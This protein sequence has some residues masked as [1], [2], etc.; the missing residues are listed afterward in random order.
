MSSLPQPILSDSPGGERAGD[1]TGSHRQPPE[2]RLIYD[3]APIGLA[4]L[5]LDCRYLQINQRLTEICGISVADHIGRSVRETVPQVADQVEKIVQL[6]LETG[7]P[8]TGIEVN[9]QRPDGTNA[10]RYWLTSWHPLRGAE[11]AIVGVNVVAEEITER[12]R[13]EAALAAS[14]ARF[15]ALV[16]ASSSLVWTTAADGQIVDMPEWRALTGQSIDEVRGWGWLHALHSDDRGRTQVVWQAAVDARSIYETEYRIRR[17]DGQYVWHQARGVA[18]FEVDGSIR[19]WVGICVDIEDRKRAA[20]QQIEA[21]TALRDLNES[22]EQRVE[23][24]A[25]ERARIWNVSQDLLVVADSQGKYLSVNPAWTATLGWSE[26][27]LVGNTSEWLLHPDDREKTRAELARLAEGRRTLQFENRLRHKTGTFCRLSWMAVPDRGLIY[28]VA[29]DVTALKDAEA[30]LQ[31]SQRELARTSRQTTMGAMTA[32]IA[33]EINQPLSAIV[34]NGSAA[35]RF[36]SH[37]EPDLEGVREGLMNIVEDGHRAGQ[38]IASIRAMFGK[39]QSAKTELD[40]DELVRQVLTIAHGELESHRVSLQ[41]HLL[42]KLPRV[43]GDRVPLQ[44]V[45]LNLIMNAIET[46][47]AVSSR[48]RILSVSSE[49]H[50]THHVLIKMRDSGAGID[51]ND[52]GRIFDAFFTTKSNGMG[53]GLAICHSIVEAHGGRLWGSAATPHGSTFHVALPRADTV[54]GQ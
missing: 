49:L 28:A 22:L 5:S 3:T 54:G 34:L 7:Q 21:E 50:D 27:E 37:P 15:R 24:E 8:I 23:M 40:L 17:W 9:G 19:E 18:V 43:L 32:S 13:A 31:R 51:P 4:F 1:L 6:I 33:H 46:M 39:E 10:E 45:F 30:A 12:K 36:L 20:Q 29:R 52:M 44:Q 26:A 48:P 16:R 35:L 47:A 38:V 25:R 42:G 14:E 41:I 53:M 2:L 11:G